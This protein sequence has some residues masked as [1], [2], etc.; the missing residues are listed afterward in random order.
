MK[1]LIYISILLMCL[2]QSFAQKN[3]QAFIDSVLQVMPNASND[4]VKAR[5]FKAISEECIKSL[6]NQAMA[7]TKIGLAFVTKMNWQKGVAVFNMNIGRIYAD[8]G[9]TDSAI[10]YY[11]ASYETYKKNKLTNF[12]AGVLNNMGVIYQNKG[13]YYKAIEYFTKA[14]QSAELEKNNET[15]SLCWQN[16][17]L[18]Y[19]EQ[20]DY[21]MSLSILKKALII[22]EQNNF[23]IKF[24][25]SYNGI[26]NCY[27]YLK[28]TVNAYYYYIKAIDNSIKF[29]NP[30]EL[31][32]AYTNLS[33]IEKSLVKNIELKLKAKKIW[34]ENYPSHLV[35]INNLTNLALE[36]FNIVKEN[37]YQQIKGSLQIPQSKN[38]LLQKAKQY[39]EVALQQSTF[40]DNKT[41][42]AYINGLLA[43]LEEYIGDY[44]NAY[45]HFRIYTAL[46]DSIYSQENKNK[47]A[48]IEGQREVLL[49]DKEIEI[50]KQKI[51]TQS[52]QAIALFI[53]IGLIALIG[54][55][56]YR[57]SQNRKKTNTQ[58]QILNKK[59]DDANKLKAKFFAILSHDLRS[60]VTNLFTFLQLQKNAPDLLSE[61]AKIIH[62]AKITYTVENLLET[63]ETMLLWSKGQMQH[64][65]PS[66]EKIAIKSVFLYLQNFYKNQ[67]DIEFSYKDA[68]NIY[69][70]TDINF[71]QTIMQ[72]LTSNAIKALENKPNGTIVWEVTETNNK[73]TISITDNGKG[74]TTE[75]I[76]SLLINENINSQNTGLGFY[77]VKDLAKAI[78]IEVKITSKLNDFCKIDLI[79]T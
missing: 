25:N 64:F 30:Q 50:N 33:V 11:N 22:Q 37:K 45:K 10:F 28:D 65:K 43:E 5:M 39:Y 59:L 46:N 73:V 3:G 51:A 54:F 13:N 41:S 66:N 58:L 19:F 68:N 27:Y 70:E 55:M 40:N 1:K 56:F 60:P 52:K 47:I 35:A 20:Q 76:N 67:V 77:I 69:I 79:A 53:V 6:P 14:L 16:I 31:A 17:G 12:E 29:D 71:L 21:N 49:R 61:D 18:V 32:T 4:T 42:I 38:E 74:L 57:Q 7:Y 2:Q 23:E 44:V 72:N 78:G 24:S 48:S 63:M 15:I 9:N 8:M 75:Q 26:A 36:F 62:Q 34:D